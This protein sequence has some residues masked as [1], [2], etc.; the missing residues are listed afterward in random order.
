MKPPSRVIALTTAFML[1][2]ACTTSANLVSGDGVVHAL[3]LPTGFESWS[4]PL[5]AAA[6]AA[7]PLVI[8]GNVIIVGTESGAL[9]PSARS[10]AHRPGAR[11]CPSGSRHR[12]WPF[13][14]TVSTWVARTGTCTRSMHGT[15]NSYGRPRSAPRSPVDRRIPTESSPS[16]CVRAVSRPSACRET[17]WSVA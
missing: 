5:G 3:E 9:V 10:M 6:G 4:K 2:A 8:A 14:Q 11:R 7:S 16:G 17:L 13:D 1:V 12:S 15:A